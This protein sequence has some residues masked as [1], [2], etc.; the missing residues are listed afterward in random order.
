MGTLLRTLS[1]QALVFAAGMLAGAALGLG[2]AEVSPA[3]QAAPVIGEARAAPAWLPT[4]DPVYPAEVVRVIDGDTFEA[5]VRIWPGMEAMTKARLRGIDAPELRA[6]CEAVRIR[7]GE[8]RA[9]LAGMLEEGGVVIRA[10]AP[11]KYGG[12]VLASAA[13]RR[14]ADLA[15]ALFAAGH[16]RRYHGGRREGWCASA[17]QR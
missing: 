5:R 8:A 2:R 3:P 11:D 13:T 9:A 4:P 14:H 1:L 15:E 16:V 7:A 6:P 17:A 10:V 12:R